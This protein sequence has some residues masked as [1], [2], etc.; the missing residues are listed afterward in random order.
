MLDNLVG[1]DV[2][3][4]AFSDKNIKL[5][6]RFNSL[7]LIYFLHLNKIT[8]YSNPHTFILDFSL[9]V[10]LKF[11]LLV[12]FSAFLYQFFAFFLDCSIYS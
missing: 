2:Y 5:K 4:K 6:V 7:L 8:I 1:K 11:W 10:A 12:S 9:L 3:V